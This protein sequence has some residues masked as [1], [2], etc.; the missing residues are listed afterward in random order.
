[1]CHL[2]SAQSRVLGAHWPLRSRLIPGHEAMASGPRGPSG[3]CPLTRR[4][5]QSHTC[6][7]ILTWSHRFRA[8]LDEHVQKCGL[9]YTQVGSYEVILVQLGIRYRRQKDSRSKNT[10]EAVI[11]KQA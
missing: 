7:Q 9:D 4:R 8:V 1:M 10:P 2:S 11:F 6:A 5:P 3:S